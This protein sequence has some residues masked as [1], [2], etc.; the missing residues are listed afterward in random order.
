M[1]DPHGQ[2]TTVIGAPGS[3]F[4]NEIDVVDPDFAYPSVFR[5]NIAYDH[6]LGFWGLVGTVEFLAASTLKDIDYENLNR[7]PGPNTLFDG[8][9]IFV[10]QVPSLSDVVLLKNT[11]EGSQWSI[12]TKLER[13]FRTPGTR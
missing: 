10:R 11:S 9:P 6:D 4:T 3:S 8:R 2:P 5:G 13:P 1:P 7:V 12:V